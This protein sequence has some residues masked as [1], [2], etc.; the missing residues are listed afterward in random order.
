[1]P[2]WRF[3]G[4]APACESPSAS[5]E[6]RLPSG[7]QVPHPFPLPLGEGRVRVLLPIRPA[8]PG[9]SGIVTSV[10]ELYILV[11]EPPDQTGTTGAL[12]RAGLAADRLGCKSVSDRAPSGPGHRPKPPLKCASGSIINP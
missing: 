10:P 12:H 2:R 11:R 7:M 4:I 1:A 3:V 9:N 5:R 8:N 6:L